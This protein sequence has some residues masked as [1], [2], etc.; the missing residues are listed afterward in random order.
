VITVYKPQTLIELAIAE[1]VLEANDIPYYVHNAGFGGL[2]PGMQLELLN[3][4]RIMVPPSAV[5]AAKEVLAFYV[6]DDPGIS[7]NRERSF[8][9]ILR[10]LAEAACGPWIVPRV[11]AVKRGAG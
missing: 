11:G 7:F 1:S 8:W 5:D 4:R 3:V 9:H 10:M 6:A 2:Y